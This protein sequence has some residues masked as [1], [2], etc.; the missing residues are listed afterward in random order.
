MLPA[1]DPS[2][3]YLPP[4]AHAADWAEV[5]Q[6]FSGNSHRAR[7]L[8]GLQGALTSLA[9]AGCKTVLLDG[10]FVTT[11][12]LPSDY[13]GA[14][15]MAGVDPGRL[16]PVLLDFKN[17]RAAMKTKFGGELFPADGFAAPGVLYR[18]FFMKDRNGVAKGVV[19]VDLGSM[20]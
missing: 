18:D 12:P 8:A 1:W 20:P 3:G 16:D 2:T 10:S 5:S 14:W 13:D 7:L 15:E 19:L 4:G 17:G 6:R 9:G 11:K